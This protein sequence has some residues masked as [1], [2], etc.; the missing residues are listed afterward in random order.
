LETVEKGGDIPGWA[1]YE[2]DVEWEAAV[3]IPAAGGGGGGAAPFAAPAHLPPAGRLP[4][5]GVL[6]GWDRHG[7]NLGV[8]F[9]VGLSDHVRSSRPG[10]ALVKESDLL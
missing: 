10:P 6:S 2:E 7:Q 8:G 1:M 5:T 4:G 9:G 3:A